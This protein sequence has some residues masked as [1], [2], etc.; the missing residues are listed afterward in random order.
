MILILIF[1]EALALY[2]LIGKRVIFAIA[3]SFLE[4]HVLTRYHLQVLD[5]HL[6]FT[7][8]IILSS[9]AGQSA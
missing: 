7:V 9:K 1:A 6:C 8:G 4:D 3:S 5:W 2:G